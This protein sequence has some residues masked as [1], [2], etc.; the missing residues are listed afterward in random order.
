MNRWERHINDALNNKLDTHFARAIRL[1][2]PNNFNIEQIDTA[3][4]Q[5][6]L[7]EKEKFWIK[8][9]NSTVNGYNMTDG[10][11]GGNTYQYKTDAEMKQIKE[12]IR[13][14]K[15]KE[16]NPNAKKV[17]CK[18]ILTNIE[19]HFNAFEE[20]VEFFGETNHS[21]ITRRCKERLKYVYKGEW[22]F[23]YEENEYIQ[24]YYLKKH[25]NRKKHINV[26]DLTTNEEKEFDSYS[27]AKKYFN[28]DYRL[29][30][31]T[32]Q[33]KGETVIIHNRFKITVLD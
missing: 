7:D 23:A 18:S 5:H 13:N 22:I 24:D 10:A 12:K 16:K 3:S 4:S 8:Y 31:K 17:K 25:Q 28:V 19:Y 2:G 32:P 11:V 14:T 21:F 33:K 6:E 1:Y 20:C 30:P 27:D 29:T 15:L 9:Y 26:V